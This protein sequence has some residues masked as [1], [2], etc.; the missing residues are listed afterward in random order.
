[1]LKKHDLFIDGL[2]V[3]EEVEVADCVGEAFH[4]LTIVVE[5]GLLSTALNIVKVE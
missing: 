5:D 1:M 4:G 2:W 3:L